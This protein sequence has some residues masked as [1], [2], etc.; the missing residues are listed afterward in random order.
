MQQAL[1]FSGGK[2]SW[3]CLW[4]HEAELAD[5]L[6]LFVD[7][8]KNLPE[9]L[10]QVE[11]AK[12]LCPRFEVIRTDR[13]G[14][15]AAWGLPSDIV[16]V[17]FT[18]LGQA[19]T[20]PQ[21]VMVQSYLDCCWA[22]ISGPLHEACHRFGV[23]D[24]ILGQRQDDGHRGLRGTGDLVGGVR[25]WHPLENWTKDQVMAYLETKMEIPPHFAL[26]HTSIDCYDCTAYRKE[27]KDKAAFLRRNYPELFAEYAERKLQLKI[28]IELAMAEG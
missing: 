1:A 18:K 25:Y 7:T 27:S 19:V 6:V 3:A 12:S 14:Q 5:T 20:S 8:G 21:P 28:A 15:N 13:E 23:T 17:N 9:V 11:K 26:Q 22:N 10:E 4:L 24:L 2:D 16:P